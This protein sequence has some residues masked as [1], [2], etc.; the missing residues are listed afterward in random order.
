MDIRWDVT[1]H[2]AANKDELPTVVWIL[3]DPPPG[4]WHVVSF[5]FWV[6]DHR[7]ERAM[8]AGNEGEADTVFQL[9]KDMMGHFVPWLEGLFNA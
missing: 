3:G 1:R 5:V 4:D 9:I 2:T 6:D 7:T 8:Y